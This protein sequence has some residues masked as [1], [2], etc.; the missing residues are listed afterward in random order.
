MPV[1]AWSCRFILHHARCDADKR[2]LLADID[3]RLVTSF[4]SVRG[5]STTPTAACNEKCVSYFLAVKNS[6]LFFVL[7]AGTVAT[8]LGLGAGGVPNVEVTIS[9][10]AGHLNY[11]GKT[12]A[13]G[14]FATHQVPAGNYVIQLKAKNAAI[15]RNDYAIFAAAGHQRVVADAISGATFTGAGVAMRL[16]P[17]AST[18][19]IGQVALG[20]V[21]ALGTKIVRGTRYVLLPPATGDLGPRWVEEGTSAARN[22]TRVRMDDPEMIKPPP[23]LIAH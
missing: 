14:V 7:F 20:G 23:A 10:A 17:T 4:A 5:Q 19:I 2:G 18:P 22:V 21:N 1:A 8:A 15:T 9:D 16:K 12:D 11:R 3:R 13:N 6:L